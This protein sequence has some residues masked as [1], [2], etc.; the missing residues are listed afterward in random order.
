[1][2]PLFPLHPLLLSLMCDF[3]AD[4]TKHLPCSW[5]PKVTGDNRQAEVLLVVVMVSLVP[6]TPGTVAAKTFYWQPPALTMMCTY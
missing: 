1:M 6:S 5:M 2:H 4:V 3:Y